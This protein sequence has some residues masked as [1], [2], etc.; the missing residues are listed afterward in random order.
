V[1]GSFEC[2]NENLGSVK[3]RVLLEYFRVYEPVC[4]MALVDVTQ[5][6]LCKVGILAKC[7]E[8]RRSIGTQSNICQRSHGSEVR[9]V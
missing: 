8:N 6:Q 9:T 7:Q 3:C 5:E 1:S 2:C 4:S